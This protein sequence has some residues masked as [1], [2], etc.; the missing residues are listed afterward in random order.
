MA[1]NFPVQVHRCRDRPG[2][3][4]D[5]CR[6]EAGSRACPVR[7]RTA[8][9]RAC[10][11]C[12]RGRVADAHLAD[13]QCVEIVTDRIKPCR[14]RVGAFGLG[15]RR[16]HREIRCRHIEIKRRN[17]ELCA[18]NGGELIDGGAAG[19]KIRHHLNRHF[20]RKSRHP[21]GGYAVVAGEDQYLDLVER[22]G[23]T[24]LPG[25]TPGGQRFQP[26]KRS[27]RFGQVAFAQSCSIFSF[28]VGRRQIFKVFCDIVVIQDHLP[29]RQQG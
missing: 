22:G 13:D 29:C 1:D 28:S 16:G 5:A 14:E 12:R 17:L 11:C 8:E 19:R 9:E 24:A 21:L 7:R 3:Q 6:V 18:L 27:C 10:K 26:A 15:H 2:F 4:R 23:V 25:R 20:R